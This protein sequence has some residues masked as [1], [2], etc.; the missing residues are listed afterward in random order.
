MARRLA[1][2]GGSTDTIAHRPGSIAHVPALDGIRGLAV[3]GVLMFHLGHLR[4]GYLGVD[5][6]FVLSGFLITSLLLAERVAAGR[7]ALA[8]FWARRARRLLPALLVLLV[9]VGLYAAT[10]APAAEVARIRGDGLATLLYGAN[11]HAIWAGHGY[12]DLFATPSPLEHTWSLAIEEQFYVVWP[13]IFVGLVALTRGSRR[14]LVLVSV[15]LAGASAVAMAM[16]F[17]PADVNRAYIGTDARAASILVGAALAF[18]WRRVPGR[19][20]S[21]WGKGRVALEVVAFVAVIGLALAWASVDGQTAGL[22]R[23]GFLLGEIAVAFVI[24]AGAHP[25]PGPI[26]RALSWKPFVALGTISYGL[27]LWHW[28]VFVWMTPARTGLDGSLLDVARLATAL[29]VAVV[30]YR[31]V[32]Q[33]VRRGRLSTRRAWTLGPALAGAVVVVLVAGTAARDVPPTASATSLAGGTVNTVPIPTLPPTTGPAGRTG[34]TPS[35]VLHD[36]ARIFVAG[37]SVAL[38]LGIGAEQ[39]ASTLKVIVVNRGYLGC[40]AAHSPGGR[41]RLGNGKVVTETPDCQK[42][43]SRWTADALA[44]QPD[45]SL[46]VLA[47]WDAADHLRDGRWQHVCQ[48]EYDAFYRTQVDDAV[49]A[50]LAGGGHVVLLTAPYLRSAVVVADQAESDRRTDCINA[51][52]R[53]S[54]AAGGTGPRRSSAA[55]SLLDAA[56]EICPP[57]AGCRKELDGVILRPDGVHYD[58]PGG[59]AMARWVIPQVLAQVLALTRQA[60][61]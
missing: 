39:V 23:G 28:P 35:P 56:A 41:V 57:D 17:D 7:V 47:A 61:P 44:F 52:I 58:G 37:D 40:G 46:L 9:V 48:P 16:L 3:A 60:A 10:V 30:S 13:L 14:A 25:K 54:V 42:G 53:A 34:T 38:T 12:F 50:L 45:V 59:P 29:G 36:P 2:V 4:G 31:I 26:A 20:D 55:V 22:Y 1:R 24:A 21:A 18:G 43:N 6:F 33:P 19:G 5:A 27:Y 51:A 8:G 49:A 32:E 15:A 11:W